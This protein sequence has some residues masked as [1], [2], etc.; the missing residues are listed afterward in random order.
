M[1]L[2]DS[3]TA[4]YNVPGG[5]RTTLYNLLDAGG[6]DIDFVGSMTDN[7][8]PLLPDLNHEGHSGWTIAG[9]SG[10]IQG[11]LAAANPDLII[12][13]IGTN[14]VSS[15]IA[16]RGVA[17]RLDFLLSQIT[18]FQP[19][20][21]LI[22][23]SIVPRLDA[24][25]ATS[26]AYNERIPALVTKYQLQGKHVTFLDMH[27]ALTTADLGDVVHPNASGYEK[28]AQAWYPAIQAVAPDPVP[29]PATVLALAAGLLCLVRRRAAR[30]R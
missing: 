27:S 17:S 13:H 12:L 21:E 29:E 20:A 24:L 6:Y 1:P 25:E 22:V 23:A 5:Y 8:N 3:I 4:G 14:D 11:W 16:P 15:G 30:S 7:P 26:Q 18:T 19:N 10:Q 9:L 28:M 2:G